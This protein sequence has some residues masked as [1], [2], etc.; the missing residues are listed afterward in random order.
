MRRSAEEHGRDPSAIEVTSGDEGV[1]G[2]EP[3]AAVERLAAKGVDRLGVPAFIFSLTPD[4][5]AAMVEF[6]ERVI[7]PSAD[8]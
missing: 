5:A 4:P 3:L 1:W 8:L 7:A 2:D 6:G